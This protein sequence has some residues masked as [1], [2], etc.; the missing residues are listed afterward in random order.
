MKKI[1]VFLL[2]VAFF[3]LTFVPVSAKP[4][5]DDI[6]RCKNGERPECHILP[7]YPGILWCECPEVLKEGNETPYEVPIPF[8][9]ARDGGYESDYTFEEI[10]NPQNGTLFEIWSLRDTPNWV[11]DNGIYEDKEL[12][13]K[14]VHYF[15]CDVE[16]SVVCNSTELLHPELRNGVYFLAID[17]TKYPG[18]GCYP[19]A[20]NG[21]RFSEDIADKFVLSTN[22]INYQRIFSGQGDPLL[23]K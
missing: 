19:I 21:E 4:A 8:I 14:Q 3:V 18:D 1:C 17:Y 6:P 12:E 5:P 22:N 7:S 9:L 23:K 15:T 20:G 2:L 16:F 13:K 11:W 10:M